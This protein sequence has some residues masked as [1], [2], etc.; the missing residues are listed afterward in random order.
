MKTETLY[1]FITVSRLRSFNAAAKE[2]FLAR[3]ALSAHISALEAELGFPL[4]DR[5]RGAELTM[6][7]SIFLAHIEPMLHNL[8]TVIAQCAER[9]SSKPIDD[10]GAIRVSYAGADASMTAIIRQLSPAPVVFLPYN[11]SK[12]LLANIEEGDP[13]IV[14]FFDVGA[15]EK[16]QRDLASL[17]LAS[18][19][20]G[21]H[22]CSLIIGAAHPLAQKTSL[23]TPDLEGCRVLLSA[24]PEFDY[25]QET[26]ETML[27]HAPNLKFGLL[28]DW[29]DEGLMNLD[30]GG[31][32]LLSMSPRTIKLFASDP[33][34]RIIRELDG[35]PF[36]F[37]Q[38][39]I[40]HQRPRSRN[41]AT[42]YQAFADAVADGT[43]AKA[44]SKQA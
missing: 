2:L 10:E 35:I 23:A 22:P 42:F 29:S 30:L 41:V 1:E 38:I 12:P 3:S 39:A 20:T 40:T 31:D 25:L 36:G 5:A 44:L 19:P 13:D 15:S 9:A 32:L 26:V 11:P 27:H 21:F 33:R 18:Q 16:Y 17:G 6:E 28:P 14:F 8:E 7:G 37:E 4:F 34:I 24:Q 43:W